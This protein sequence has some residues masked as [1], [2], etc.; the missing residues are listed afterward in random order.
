MRTA[1]I[2]TAE[3]TPRNVLVGYPNHV[4]FM[5]SRQPV[6]VSFPTIFDDVDYVS[7]SVTVTSSGRT[8]TEIRKI[9]QGKAEFDIGRTM[10]L[11]ADDV[12]TV[13]GKRNPLMGVK[14]NAPFALSVDFVTLAGTKVH[15]MDVSDITGMY[16]ALDQGETYGQPARRRLWVNFPQTFNIWRNNKSLA[17]FVIDGEY[18]HP[19]EAVSNICHECDL[20]RKLER[21]GKTDLIDAFNAGLSREIGLTWAYALAEG[22]ETTQDIQS[23]TIVPDCSKRTDGTY[24]RWINRRGELSHWLFINSRLRRTTTVSESFVRYYEGDPAVPTNRQYDNPQKATYREAQEMSLC[25]V[26]LTLDEYEDLCSLA[27]S[28][29]VQMLSSD[30]KGL[31]CWQRVN[32]VAGTFERN[33]RRNTPSLQDLEILIELPER[34]TIQL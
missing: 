16:G 9:Y 3:T 13:L 20:L 11:L 30:S 25:A 19:V 32:V 15:V 5:Y 1:N 2:K 27:T 6:T 22:D 21:E 4:A 29:V 10:Q 17:S 34:N 7:V 31:D 8:H 28:P 26:G 33:I 23:L 24:L 18:L 12:D 14:L